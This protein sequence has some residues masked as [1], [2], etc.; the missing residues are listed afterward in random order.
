MNRA[1]AALGMYD[2]PAQ[3][4]ANDRL[5]AELARRLRA[6]DID[7]PEQLDRTRPVEAIWRD[8]LLLFGQACGYPLVSDPNLAL[9]VIGIPVYAAPG[10]G[11]GTH[12]SHIVVRAEDADTSLA[13]Y[14]GRPVAINARHSNTGHNLLRAAV[15][16]LAREGRFF[17]TVVETGSHRASI[18][19]VVR[20]T[21]DIAAID[22]I[23]HAALQ[24]FEPEAV[25]GL[26]ILGATAASP[27]LPF[28]TA[29]ATRI[30][31]VA[32]LRIALAAVMADPALADAR[33]ALFLR[34]VIPGGVERYAAVRTLEIAAITAGYPSLR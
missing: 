19:A 11:V 26:R 1:V 10:C 8:P 5:W 16:P 18:D 12:V 23:S 20:G 32:A 29:R 25:A 4:A 27:T 3:R 28:V 21:A 24:R 13:D 14:R 15:A 9:R 17:A 31:T 33:D 30:E 34:D 2:R 7:A 22:S 6:H